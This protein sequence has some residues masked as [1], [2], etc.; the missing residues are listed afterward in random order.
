[1]SHNPELEDYNREFGGVLRL[2]GD[3]TSF[4]SA[5]REAI[6]GDE[7]QSQDV[8]RNVAAK[9]AWTAILD[10]MSSLIEHRL[11]SKCQAGHPS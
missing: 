1:V 6:G 7:P 10:F 4:V 9:N 2:A 5:L 8:Y 3:A 11:E